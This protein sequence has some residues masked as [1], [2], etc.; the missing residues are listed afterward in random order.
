M[1]KVGKMKAHPPLG[2]ELV[3]ASH[4]VHK[5]LTRVLIDKGLQ[6]LGDAGAQRLVVCPGFDDTGGFPAPQIDADVAV[7]IA[8]GGKRLS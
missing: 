6:A 4:L 5:R 7:E 3:E 8:E 1:W 2:K